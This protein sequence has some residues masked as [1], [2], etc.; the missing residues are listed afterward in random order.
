MVGYEYETSML[1]FYHID[2]SVLVENRP[3]VKFIR[4]YV[5]DSSGA[6]HILTS[7]DIDDVVSRLYTVVCAKMLLYI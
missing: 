6:I 3:L 2:K 5:R 1:P 7:E 4:N